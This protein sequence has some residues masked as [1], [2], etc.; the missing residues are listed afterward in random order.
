MATA[1]AERGERRRFDAG[2]ARRAIY[3]DFEGT[4]VDPPSLLGVLVDDEFVQYVFEPILEPAARAKSTERGGTCVFTTALDTLRSV[5]RRAEAEDRP[6]VAWSDRE[7]NA[8]VELVNNADD[9]AF[10]ER[11]IVNAIPAARRWKNRH[12]RDL[13]FPRGPQGRSGRNVLARYVDLVGHRVP[14]LHG[15]GDTAARIRFV[16]AALAKRGTFEALTTVQRNKW[17]NLLQHNRHDCMGLRAVVE[18]VA[19]DAPALSSLEAR[20]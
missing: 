9:R 2:D 14:R 5:R 13:V 17:A 3:I 12:H 19:L 10:W 20:P 15:P 16:R 18:Q 6:V 8:I 7:R 1:L 4:A 11:T